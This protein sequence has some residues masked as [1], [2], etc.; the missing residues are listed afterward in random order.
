MRVQNAPAWRART[1][2][3]LVLASPRAEGGPTRLGI[4]ASRKVGS[5][6]VR[7][8][9]KRLVREAFRMISRPPTGWDVV[10]VVRAETAAAPLAAIGRELAGALRALPLAEGE[11]RSQADDPTPR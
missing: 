8:R 4:V 1:R 7:N 9:A 5:A 2:H 10:V 11:R 3:L 6:V